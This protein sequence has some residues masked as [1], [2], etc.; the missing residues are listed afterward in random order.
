MAA[1]V[2]RTRKS[3]AP[4][5]P[6]SEDGLSQLPPNSPEAEA[7]VLGCI[8]LDPAGTLPI[9]V[10]QFKAGSAVFFDLKHRTIYDHL[11]AMWDGQRP[12]DAITLQ[13]QLRDADQLEGIGGLAYLAGLPDTVP[14]SANLEVYAD[15]V[16]KKYALRRVL[17]AC[18]EIAGQAMANPD[19]V[20]EILAAASSAMDSVSDVTAPDD[21][22]SSAKLLV[23]EAM[24]HIEK[25]RSGGMVGIPTGLIDLDTMTWGLQPATMVT[26]AARPSVGKTALAMNIADHVAV[27]LKMPVGVFSLEMSKQSLM[28]RM[29]C[30]RARVSTSWVQSGNLTETSASK[31]VTASTALFKAPLYIDDS[32][33]LSVLQL[34]ARAR[35]MHKQYGIKLFIIDYLQLMSAPVRRND[36][37]Q[38][39]VSAISGGL[40][41]LSKDLNV[42]VLVLSQLSRKIDDRGNNAKPRLSDLRESGSIEQDSDIVILLHKPDKEIANPD[43]SY[44][45]TIEVNALVAKHR[46]GP[47]GEV[48]LVFLRSCTT[49]T[50]KV[51]HQDHDAEPEPDLG[52]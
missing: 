30:S 43:G 37:R 12:I 26:L 51:C 33:M 27:H 25:L 28:V 29:L 4:E 46:S 16:V 44:Q 22:V 38:Q 23:P 41:A 5:P 8:L 47:T 39:E 7:G 50:S 36:N 11:V 24:E 48:S 52:I 15:I 35:R 3:K 40:K 19:N 13:Q 18:T 14:S 45:E 1:P 20:N 34:R 17:A 42:P 9:C 6:P 10:T 31:L 32:S 21:T 2:T 49:F